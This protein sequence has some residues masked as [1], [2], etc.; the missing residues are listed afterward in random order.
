MIGTCRQPRS[1]GSASSS[2]VNS[3]PT[4]ATNAAPTTTSPCY[5]A[6]RCGVPQQ[7]RYRARPSAM[8]VPRCRRRGGK[9][10]KRRRKKGK[11]KGG[12][13]DNGK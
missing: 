11:G 6:E 3:L 4:P 8:Q 10:R 9:G 7:P 1:D 13:G 5:T 12:R 2:L